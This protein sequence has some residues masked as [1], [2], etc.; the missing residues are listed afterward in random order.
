MRNT[1]LLISS[2][3]VFIACNN[4]PE[5][6]TEVLI[7]KTMKE[8]LFNPKTYN[9]VET[10]VDSAFS[11]KDDPSFFELLKEFRDVCDDFNEQ[12][13]I[14][15]EAKSFSVSSRKAFSA[16]D[17]YNAEYDIAMEKAEMLLSRM[18]KKFHELEQLSNAEPRFIGY[19]AIH[20]YRTKNKV[21]ETIV[22]QNVFIIDEKCESV[23]FFCD[24]KEYD[25]FQE[26]VGIMSEELD[27]KGIPIP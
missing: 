5:E 20:T 19:R 27:G 3:I 1:I 7:N 12:K 9:P 13:S 11:P 22:G 17:E 14:V 6:K 18:L 8:C 23:L 2:A 24:K 26:G 4:S 21:G 15:N 25:H 10:I 16:D